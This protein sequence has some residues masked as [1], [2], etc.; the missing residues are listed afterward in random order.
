MLFFW[1][2]WSRITTASLLN[3]HEFS[4]EIWFFPDCVF[5]LFVDPSTNDI[6]SNLLF[7]SFGSDNEDRSCQL[8]NPQLTKRSLAFRDSFSAVAPLRLAARGFRQIRCYIHSK[9]ILQ[10]S[11]EN[12]Q[13]DTSAEEW[14]QACLVFWHCSIK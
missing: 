5:S 10:S 9:Y 4:H 6:K 2:V 7:V 3:Y 12:N 14:H 1:Y 8:R 11:L 13:W